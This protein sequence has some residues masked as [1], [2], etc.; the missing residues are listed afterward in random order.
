M[1]SFIVNS[2]DL[3]DKKKNPKLSLSVEDTI[4][5]SKIKKSGECEVCG[6][7]SERLEEL[8]GRLAC[9]VCVEEAGE[10]MDASEL[11]MI[12][13]RHGKRWVLDKLNQ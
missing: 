6:K 1:K 11:D 9:P 3:F 8:F 7:P 10:G 13:S 2:K 5:N 12:V 4:K